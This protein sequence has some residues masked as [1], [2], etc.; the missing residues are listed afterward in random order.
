V[1]T[2]A[3]LAWIASLTRIE[4]P[5]MEDQ[6]STSARRPGWLILSAALNVVLVSA[7][8]VAV[9]GPRLSHSGSLR[10]TGM[11]PAP[12]LSRHDLRATERALQSAGFSSEEARHVVYLMVAD[13]AGEPVP[14][15]YWKPASARDAAERIAH[16]QRDEV[17]RTTLTRIYGDDAAADSAFAPAFRPYQ[18]ELPMLASDQQL[19]LQS[20]RVE[21]LKANGGRVTAGPRPPEMIEATFAQDLRDETLFEYQLR[22]SPLARGLSALPFDFTEQEFRESFRALAAA[23]PEGVM[24]PAIAMTA[25]WRDP[26]LFSALRSVLGA[27]RYAQFDRMRDP[28]YMMLRRIGSMHGASDDK[29]NQAYALM[30]TSG[31]SASALEPKLS[32]LL[33]PEA[34]ADIVRAYDPVLRSAGPPF[35]GATMLRGRSDKAAAREPSN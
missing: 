18:R 13:S 11:P 10:A 32:G 12:A 1:C 2:L 27:E 20:L 26:A 22:E 5:F 14:Y 31:A 21:Q 30:N 15:E 24:G 25:M 7:L 17:A 19:R 4:E 6:P 23:N 16:V 34:A 8:A 29:I 35:S 9:V 3:L 28:R 33:G